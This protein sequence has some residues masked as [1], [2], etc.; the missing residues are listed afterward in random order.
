MPGRKYII[1]ST[2]FPHC[3]WEAAREDSELCCDRGL[4]IS[5]PSRARF[6]DSRTSFRWSYKLQGEEPNGFP[7]SFSRIR[8][9]ERRTSGVC[10]MCIRLFV[11]VSIPR[12]QRREEPWIF[13]KTCVRWW[14]LRRTRTATRPSA[15]RKLHYCVQVNKYIIVIRCKISVMTVVCCADCLRFGAKNDSKRARFVV[16]THRRGWGGSRALSSDC[17]SRSV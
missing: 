14:L 5:L 6:S 3:D 7:L 16:C 12:L 9:R 15:R 13:V 2:R 10:K 17:M 11:I 4:N 1:P 8:L